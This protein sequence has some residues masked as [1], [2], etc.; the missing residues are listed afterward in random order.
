MSYFVYILRC[1]DNSYYTGV[2][3]NIQKRVYEHSHG[4]VKGYTFKRLPI[5]LVYYQEFTKIND[6]ISFEKQLKGWRRDKKEALIKG[7]IKRLKKLSKSH[8]S[9]PSSSSG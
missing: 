1:S 6:A 2:T 9:H 4:L 5:Q 8:F 7:D 3:N